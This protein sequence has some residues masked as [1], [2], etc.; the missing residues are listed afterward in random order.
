MIMT[1]EPITAVALSA[2]VLGHAFTWLQVLGA[3]IT[4]VAG[5]AFLRQRDAQATVPR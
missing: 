2:A 5:I 1:L 3:A 4:L